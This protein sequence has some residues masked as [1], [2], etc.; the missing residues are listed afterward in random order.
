[1]ENRK[2]LFIKWFIIFACILTGGIIAGTLGLF[3]TVLSADISHLT[4]VI[5]ALFLACSL[6]AGK[7]SYD[8]SEND[9]SLHTDYT[10]PTPK[11]KR[12][13]KFLDFMADSFF[14]LGLMGTIIGF[15]YMMRSA[16]NDTQDI[17]TIITQLKVGS[18]TKLFTTLAGIV[19]SLLL[20]F[21]LLII[22]TDLV[23]DKDNDNL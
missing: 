1:M 12:K 9:Y 18:S 21:Q 4:T 19:S 20:Q 13:L 14:T 7:I 3:Q 5:A 16:L 22:K 10:G 8:L 2:Y 15:C 6:Q 11:L 17:S 23:G